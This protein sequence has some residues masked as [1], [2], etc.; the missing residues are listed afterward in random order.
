M[1]SRTCCLFIIPLDWLCWFYRFPHFWSHLFFHTVR[2]VLS[3]ITSITH[4]TPFLVGVFYNNF[5]FFL[6]SRLFLIGSFDLAHHTLNYTGTGRVILLRRVKWVARPFTQSTLGKDA[7]ASRRVIKSLL[8][9]F[10]AR[11]SELCWFFDTIPRGGFLF[12]VVP[13]YYCWFQNY[14]HDNHAGFG[15]GWTPA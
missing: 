8:E 6:L 3:H 2:V 4:F 15:L 9:T 5:S 12:G 1:R 11:G 14:T 7:L 10:Y 13:Y